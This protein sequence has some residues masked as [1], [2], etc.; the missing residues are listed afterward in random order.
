MVPS[1]SNPGSGFRGALDYDFRPGK[2][3]ELLGGTMRAETPP[4]LAAEF[5]GWRALNEQATKPV[6]HCS[7]SAAPEDQLSAE[8]WL[9]VAGDFVQR[10]GYGNSPWVAI[11]HRDRAI[12]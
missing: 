1:V 8:R 2:Q 10:M 5:G 4:G 12:D 3:P 9:E 11:R 6:F 7:L